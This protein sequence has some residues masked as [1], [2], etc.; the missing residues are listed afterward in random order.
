MFLYF[1]LVPKKKSEMHEAGRVNLGESIE[2]TVSI[3]KSFRVNAKKN[4]KNTLPAKFRALIVTWGH[5][6]SFLPMVW[7]P[8]CEIWN[9]K[10]SLFLC[11]NFRFRSSHSNVFSDKVFLEISKNW[12]KDTCAT[13]SF[14]DKVWSLRPATLLKRRPWQTRFPMNFGN[15]LKSSFLKEHLWWLLL[16]FWFN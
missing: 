4:K 14:F 5:F 8:R 15:F 13:N 3:T 2:A 7:V 16:Q 12:Q 10:M 11:W 9:S 6:L 1:L